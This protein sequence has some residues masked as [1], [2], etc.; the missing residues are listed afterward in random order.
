MKTDEQPT[1]TG[2]DRRMYAIMN[3]REGAPLHATAARRRTVVVTHI[4][5]TAVGIACWLYS[6]LGDERWATFGMLGVLLPWCVA[7]GVING[8]TRGLLELRVRVLDERQRAE[9]NRVAA[10]AQ[11][12]MMW[13][14]LAVTV[15]TGL[16]G[17]A[18]VEIEGLIFPVLFSVF[19]VHWLMPLWLA[20]LMAAD[21]LP[22]EDPAEE[23][24]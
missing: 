7:A 11:Y 1:I 20:G 17:F 22:E 15:G 10:R 6:V 14:L 18:G 24:A 13:L 3:R 12:V 4:A 9:K 21:D 8:A 16:A 23:G 5:L 2:Y 19:V